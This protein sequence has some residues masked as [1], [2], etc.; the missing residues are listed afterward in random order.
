[1]NKI[2]Q[3]ITLFICVNTFSQDFN[4]SQDGYVD[5]SGGGVF[6]N[7]DGSGIDL[8]I[9]GL[10]NDICLSTS[11]YLGI[12]NGQATGASS[13][14]QFTFSENVDVQ[15]TINDINMDLGACY[16]D[17]LLFTGSPVFTNAQNITIIGDTILP[18]PAGLGA[19]VTVTYYNVTAFSITHGDGV[20]CN[21]GY[22]SL[23]T[24]LI[25]NVLSINEY[26]QSTPNIIL[27]KNNIILKGKFV[28]K[29][30]FSIFDIL[31]KELNVNY[32]I[33]DDLIIESNY[34]PN[35]NYIIVFEYLGTI[36]RERFVISH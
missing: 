17:F 19:S 22:I 11:L 16:Y 13:I 5:N 21:P 36:Q 27:N 14:Y 28:G 30:K 26:S 35:G 7:I 4:C 12:N 6:T 31:G 25:N 3:V 33:V 29:P 20:S 1:M 2:I 8:T 24:V 23:S 32:E 15:F 9:S 34:L 18:A 10:V